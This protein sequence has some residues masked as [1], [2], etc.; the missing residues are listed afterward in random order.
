MRSVKNY[1]S[2]MKV[3]LRESLMKF[4][5]QRTTNPF[6]SIGLTKGAA[7]IL[8]I[9]EFAMKFLKSI[10]MMRMPRSIHHNLS[11]EWKNWS[12]K[13]QITTLAQKHKKEFKSKWALNLALKIY[14]LMMK[15][16]RD[17]R[18]YIL[19]LTRKISLK[20][21]MNQSNQI[22]HLEFHLNWRIYLIIMIVLIIS[23]IIIDLLINLIRRLWLNLI[24]IVLVFQ[25]KKMLFLQE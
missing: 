2:R 23:T 17:S 6:I 13:I 20:D 16:K 21:S 10:L 24:L 8:P 15:L 22:I 14:K 3:T 12:I 7:I 4:K 1:S 19:N 18:I 11:K 9:R 5:S 25:E